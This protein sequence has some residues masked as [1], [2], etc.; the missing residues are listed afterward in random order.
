MTRFFR[1]SVTSQEKIYNP[2]Y[3]FVGQQ[4][5][6]TS[7]SH[8]ITLQFCLWDF[9]RDLGETNVGGEEMIKNLDDATGFDLDKISTARLR[10][11]ARAYA[12][13]IVKDSVT[14]AILKPL[15]FTVLKPRTHAFL[16]E[17]FTQLLANTQLST[18]LLTSDVNGYP[19]TRNRGAVEEVFIK[20]TRIQTLALG[21]VYFLGENFQGR[22]IQDN[23]SGFMQW[24]A[25]VA[26]GTLRT[27]AQVVAGL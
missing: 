16:M 7:H 22:A 15:D 10:N 4:L 23:E 17:L 14:L 11:V 1:F 21:L 27:G 2:Y 26:V 6:R 13:W 5:C 12:W 19:T 20:A 18:P 24:A 8:K 9:L 25:K 3:T